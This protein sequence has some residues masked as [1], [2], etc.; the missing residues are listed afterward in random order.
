MHEDPERHGVVAV[1]VRQDRFLVIRRSASVCAPRA[2]CFPGGGIEPGETEPQALMRELA[3][4]LGVQAFP[5]RRVW[6]SVTPWR[7]HLAWWTAQLAPTAKVVPNPAEVE[8]VL[9]RT[10]EEIGLLP[11]LLSSNRDFLDGLHAGRIRL[12]SDWA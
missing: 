9:W 6:R 2:Y 4:E 8:S 3:E 1:I 12:A 10:T 7:V 5:G 11:G